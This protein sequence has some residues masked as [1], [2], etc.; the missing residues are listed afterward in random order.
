MNSITPN[1]SPS[2]S[3]APSASP[4]LTP[5]ASP[6]TFPQ[7]KMSLFVKVFFGCLGVVFVFAL[8]ALCLYCASS[9]RVGEGSTEK[10]V[11]DLGAGEQLPLGV[12]IGEG[13]MA[14]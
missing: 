8:L 13:D 6:S 5:S 7:P 1:P 12:T 4:I 3:S 10:A 2:P 11:V 9:R 14:L